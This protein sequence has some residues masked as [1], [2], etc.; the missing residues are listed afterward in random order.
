MTIKGNTKF[1]VMLHFFWNLPLIYDNVS[2][3]GV[4]L[5]GMGNIEW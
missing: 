1:I 2:C 5:R 4:V 3:Y